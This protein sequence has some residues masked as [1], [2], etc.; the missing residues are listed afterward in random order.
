MTEHGSA[1]QP[2]VVGL[3][4][5]G[6]TA[7]LRRTTRSLDKAIVLFAEGCTQQ[8]LE[9]S[10][11]RS[12]E[13]ATKR[14]ESMPAR[15]QSAVESFVSKLP[16]A[17]RAN[18]VAISPHRYMKRHRHELLTRVGLDSRGDSEPQHP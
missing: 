3:R 8:P 17:P 4:G 6:K 15:L 12:L 9:T 1:P 7:L 13:R 5:M 18:A 2:V 16:K 10:F 11:R 14:L